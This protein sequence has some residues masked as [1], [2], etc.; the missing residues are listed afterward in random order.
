LSHGRAGDG[1]VE[2]GM[3]FE[4]S[5][6]Q[7]AMLLDEIAGNPADAHELQE[8]LRER[9]TE[10]QAMGLPL[11]EDLVGLEEY[12]EDDLARPARRRRSDENAEE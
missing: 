10:M 4:E 12:L 2:D 3:A 6:L 5:R 8:T 1:T 7:I 11:P 9:L